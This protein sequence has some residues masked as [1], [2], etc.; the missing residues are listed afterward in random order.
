[1]S[2]VFMLLLR[3]VIDRTGR[4]LTLG[5]TKMLV[6]NFHSIFSLT[7]NCA[8]IEINIC[9]MNLLSTKMN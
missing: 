8:S 1:M 3:G 5:V 4:H 7:E 9:E 2:P 6:S